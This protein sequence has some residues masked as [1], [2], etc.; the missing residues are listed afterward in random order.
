[1][2]KVAVN[3]KRLIAVKDRR[4][5]TVGIII[6]FIWKNI[7]ENKVRTF[8]ILFSIILFVALFFASLA[9]SDSGGFRV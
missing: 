7:K 9:I 1:M 6:K 3:F 4:G 5:L 8:L 2:E